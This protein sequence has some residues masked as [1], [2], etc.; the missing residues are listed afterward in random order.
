MKNLLLILI[1]FCFIVSSCKDD[2]I[3][4]TNLTLTSEQPQWEGVE[5]YNISGKY[6]LR[7]ISNG[8]IIELNYGGSNAIVVDDGIYNITFD[9]EI[10][11]A[12]V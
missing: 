1:T 9:G 2:S 5:H 6:T 7:N 12:H 10:G 3:S 8:Q 4:Q 11:R